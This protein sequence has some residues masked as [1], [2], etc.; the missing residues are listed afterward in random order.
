MFNNYVINTWLWLLGHRRHHLGSLVPVNTVWGDGSLFP[1]IALKYYRYMDTDLDF[2][3][4]AVSGTNSL[5][6]NGRAVQP[7]FTDPG[8]YEV[9]VTSGKVT[10]DLYYGNLGAGGG[11]MIDAFNVNQSNWIDDDFVKVY[12]N[13]T[14]NPAET[15]SANDEGI[16]SGA[17]E[18]IE[19]IDVDGLGF[20]EWDKIGGLAN[21]GSDYTKL[22]N[23]AGLLIA[24]YQNMPVPVPQQD[25]NQLLQRIHYLQNTLNAEIRAWENSGSPGTEPS[26]IVLLRSLIANYLK[27]Y[28][29]GGCVF[30][31]SSPGGTIPKIPGE[32]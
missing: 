4:M 17:S 31:V 30:P 18:T 5:S 9:A 15:A 22:I 32:N 1:V 28:Q 20:L 19:A 21:T 25:C 7:P 11:M 23:E 16:L 27:E 14:L 13:G 12:T 10:I 3:F 29:Q 2:L 6:Y 8:N 24:F 26:S